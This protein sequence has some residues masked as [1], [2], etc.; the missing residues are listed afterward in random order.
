M[1]CE[2]YFRKTNLPLFFFY[3]SSPANEIFHMRNIHFL[4]LI[5]FFIINTRKFQHS[6]LNLDSFETF[7]STNGISFAKSGRKHPMPYRYL[8]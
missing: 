1:M 4:I 3:Q 5:R 2:L 8:L 7:F 6:D